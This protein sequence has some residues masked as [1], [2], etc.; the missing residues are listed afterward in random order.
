MMYKSTFTCKEGRTLVLFCAVLPCEAKGTELNSK[1]VNPVSNFT[2][3]TLSNKRPAY[4]E[5][6]TRAFELAPAQLVIH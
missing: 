2:V 3:T 5:R 1:I 6:A 4:T